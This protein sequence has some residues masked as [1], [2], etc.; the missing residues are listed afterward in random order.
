MSRP[1]GGSCSVFVGN[2]PYDAQEDEIRDLFSKVAPC[3]SVRLVHDKETRQPKGYAFA[4]FGDPSAVASAIDKLNNIEYNGRRLRIDYAERE[5]NHIGK[6]EGKAA[7]GPAAL[8]GPSSAPGMM[9]PVLPLPPVTTVAD[10]LARI[11]EQEAAEHARQAALEQW[12]LFEIARFVETLTPLQLFHI[13]GEMQRLTLSAPEV[14]RALLAENTQLCIALQHAQFLLGLADEPPLPTDPEVRERA[15]CVKEKVFGAPPPDG[16]LGMGMN[17]AAMQ[18]QLAPG[19]LGLTATARPGFMP[20]PGMTGMPIDLTG[21]APLA[22]GDPLISKLVQL[23]PAQ[24][25][26]LPHH[27]KVQ[28][29]QYLQTLTPQAA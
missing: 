14:G 16:A 25:D 6:G 10:R 18:P 3:S 12:E 7:T 23:T 20:T 29:L 2:V 22:S 17:P 15:K 21:G 13:V 4:D 24:I 27:T 9:D 1:A 28:V 5:L 19:L 8:P 11:R 26:Q